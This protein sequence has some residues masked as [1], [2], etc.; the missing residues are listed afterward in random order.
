MLLFL[1]P[2][3]CGGQIPQPKPN[4]YVNDY[5]GTLTSLETRTLN[6]QIRELEKHTTVQ[7]AVVL[8]N[9]LPESLSIEEYARG[10]GNTWKVGNHF[11]GLVYVAVLQERRHRLEV[12]RNL[13]VN[14][15]D[16]TAA[17]IIE[18]LRPY[19]RGQQYFDGLLVLI[20]KLKDRLGAQTRELWDTSGYV[21]LQEAAPTSFSSEKQTDNEFLA[22]KASYDRMGNYAIWAVI[23]GLIGF[24]IWAWRYK[25]TYVRDRTIDGVYMGIGSAHY[26]SIYGDEDEDSGA[27][28]SG[29]GGFGGSGGGGFS[30]GGASDSW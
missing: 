30:G 23:L 24:C 13:E 5:T 20:T 25:T 19:L 16:S 12:A 15:P 14:L 29:F 9:R 26:A 1:V 7:L 28:A 10:I 17:A 22:K 18:S 3:L 11:N 21:P 8:V 2:C 27:D 4:T 6:E